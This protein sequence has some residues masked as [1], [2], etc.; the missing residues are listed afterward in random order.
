[1][2]RIPYVDPSILGEN[3]RAGFECGSFQ[4]CC[5]RGHKVALLISCHTI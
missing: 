3:S 2:E 1:M 4:W 5:L